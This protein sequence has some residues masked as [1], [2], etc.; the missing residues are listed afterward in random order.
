LPLTGLI[1]V[2][3]DADARGLIDLPQALARLQ[4]TTFHLSPALVKRLGRG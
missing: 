4:G 3:L 1:G 2:L